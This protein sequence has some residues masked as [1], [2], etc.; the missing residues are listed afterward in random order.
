MYWAAHEAGD[1]APKVMKQT[2][3]LRSDN[4]GLCVSPLNG[5]DFLLR[6]FS[7]DAYWKM[8]EWYK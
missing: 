5:L 8:T 4:G 2:N 7:K 1:R 6:S 3:W